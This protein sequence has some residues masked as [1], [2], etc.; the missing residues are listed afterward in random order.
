[1]PAVSKAQ[2]RFMA[3]VA[4]GKLKKPGLTP[5]K[6]QDFLHKSKGSYK[7]LPGH[8]LHGKPIGMKALEAWRKKHPV[9]AR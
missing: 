1:M 4:S 3:A 9:K 8:T 5:A 6:A 2:F 7:N